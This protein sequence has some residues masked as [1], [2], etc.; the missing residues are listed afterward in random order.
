[1]SWNHV[2]GLF[3]LFLWGQISHNFP[4]FPHTMWKRKLSL[5]RTAHVS[6]TIILVAILPYPSCVLSCVQ[7]FVTPWTVAHQA[8]LSVE[9]SRQKYWTGL[10]F[11]SLVDFPDLGIKPTS[12][13]S[14]AMVGR[15]FITVLPGKSYPSLGP[16]TLLEEG[17]SFLNVLSL[18]SW[19]QDSRTSG[20]SAARV[21][22]FGSLENISL[23]LSYFSYSVMH[24]CKI[25]LSS[26][27]ALHPPSVRPPAACVTPFSLLRWLWVDY[28]LEFFTW[29]ST[30]FHILIVLTFP[31]SQD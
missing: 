24:L 21:L 6:S 9:F 3:L 4:L 5:W 19:L 29:L 30:L 7:L 17:S 12:L 15:F 28:S 23:L 10:P 8:P 1:M 13:A 27:H 22:R 20:N 31:I 16:S 26:S 14:S 2:S 18:F 11:P 25:L